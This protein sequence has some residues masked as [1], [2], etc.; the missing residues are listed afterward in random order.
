MLTLLLIAAQ[1]QYG[2]TFIGAVIAQDGVVVASDS[3]TTLL[4]ENSRGFGYVDGM[5]KIFV[6]SGP[7]VAMS[8]LTNLEGDLFSSFVA[9][10][11]YL[12]SRP[13]N[14]ILFGFLV[15]LP[16]ANSTG[17]GLISAG[18]LEGKPLVC[19]KAP[20]VPQSCTSSGYASNKDS[21]ILRASIN[22]LGRIPTTAEAAAI[23]REAIEQHARMDPTIGGPISILKLTPTGAP[24]WLANPPSDQGWSKVCDMVEAHRRGLRRIT[25]LGSPQ[26][27]DQ[28]LN[29]ICPKH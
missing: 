22:K 8:G 29:G 11:D 16:F 20:I 10:N 9:R 18:Y 14:E 27:L 26:E 7:A 28:R 6:G 24:Q 25:P 13:A 23:L 4:D 17:V 21:S 5:P 12:L 3:R 1:M 19:W 2:G 15:W